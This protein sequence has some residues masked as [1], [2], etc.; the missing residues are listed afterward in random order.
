MSKIMARPQSSMHVLLVK[1]TLGCNY[2]EDVVGPGCPRC[3]PKDLIC[4]RNARL[5]NFE[6][7]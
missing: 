3:E 7:C 1:L 2:F 5:L 4:S 6:D